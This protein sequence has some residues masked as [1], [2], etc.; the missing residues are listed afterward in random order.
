MTRQ[1]KVP[2]TRATFADTSSRGNPALQSKHLDSG[3]TPSRELP[4]TRSQLLR[5][6]PWTEP[7]PVTDRPTRRDVRLPWRED[8]GLKFRTTIELGGKTA[9]GFRVPAEVVGEL[10]SGKKPR[11]FVRIAGYTYR[12]T[13]AVYGDEFMLPLSAENR[14]KAGA[15]AGE[16][17]DVNLDLDTVPRTVSVPDELASALDDDRTVRRRFDELSYSR[18]RQYVDSVAGAKTTATRQRRITRTIDALREE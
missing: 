2:I 4:A 8:D 3:M 1:L 10:G 17:V 12:S 7:V 6:R 5:T 18:Q 9:T 11:V 13:V 15:V 14:A 16:E